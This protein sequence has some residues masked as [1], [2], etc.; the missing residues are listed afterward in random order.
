[1]HNWYGID[2]T[3]DQMASLLQSYPSLD[4]EVAE[5]GVDTL[6]RE[7][8]IEALNEK[9]G[10]ELSWP[11]NGDSPERKQAYYTSFH[12]VAVAAGYRVLWT[13]KEMEQVS[14]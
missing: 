6:T 4:G 13:P 1:M 11:I 12:P 7:K 9:L 10:I 3:S 2:M 14:T 5:W 8:L